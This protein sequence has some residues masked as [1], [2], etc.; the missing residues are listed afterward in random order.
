MS[1]AVKAVAGAALIYFSAG[2]ASY[3]LTGGAIGAMTATQAMLLPYIS[4]AITLVGA[5]LAGSALAPEM[6][7]TLG[8]DAYAGQKLQTKRDNVS[9]VP[10]IFGENRVGSNVIWQGTSPVESGAPNK[11][12]WSV[13]IVAEGEVEDYLTMY[14]NE[15]TMVKNGDVF[16]AKYAQ[17][18]A[19]KTSG[20]GML[21]SDIDFVRRED[22][23][24][25]GGGEVV[26]TFSSGQLSS[27]TNTSELPNLL[28]GDTETY[29]AQMTPE[30]FEE[31]VIKGFEEYKTNFLNKLNKHTNG[32]PNE[33]N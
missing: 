23:T 27:N 18:K 17:V 30:E 26:G 2:L 19:Y 16:T 14:Q 6:P 21:L 28:D 1:K 33:N 9:A 31:K 8:A 20:S 22:G 4:G 15:N 7:D 3:A 24:L 5:S 13:Q 12:Y 10:I 25:I 29:A 32:E 11:D